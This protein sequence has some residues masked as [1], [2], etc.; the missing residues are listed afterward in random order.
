M[1]KPT[2]YQHDTHQNQSIFKMLVNKVPL[3]RIVAVLE[4]S[5]NLPY[6]RIDY[7]HRQCLAFAADRERRL[8][9][10]PIRRLYL[11]VDRQE[12]LVSW[13]K[14]GD[15][16]NVSLSA[17]ASEDNETGYV[18]DVHPNFNAFINQEDVEKDAHAIGDAALAAPYRK[19]AHLLLSHD[20]LKSTTSKRLPGLRVTA[21]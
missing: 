6:P 11:A 5:C 8:K 12:H 14:R 2:Q 19:Y 15:K 4:I 7:I 20:Y 18:F 9:D 17:I 10:L 1:S 16:R 21:R 13:T 3:S